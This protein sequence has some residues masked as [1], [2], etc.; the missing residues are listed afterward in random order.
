MAKPA[1]RR[2][3]DEF[4]ASNLV[5]CQDVWYT[6]GNI[7]LALLNVPNAPTTQAH[8]FRVH[9]SILSQLSDVWRGLFALAQP[10]S[11][12]ETCAEVECVRFHGDNPDDMRE[13]LQ[14]VYCQRYVRYARFCA[15]LADVGPSFLPNAPLQSWRTTERAVAGPLRIATKYGVSFLR[16]RIVQILEADWPSTL[17]GWNA[18]EKANGFPTRRDVRNR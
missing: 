18:N 11:E 13:F 17:E 16:D 5:R 4:N 12:V 3:E 14:I 1:P 15:S 7:V 9:K 8:V 6:D 2:L 10:S